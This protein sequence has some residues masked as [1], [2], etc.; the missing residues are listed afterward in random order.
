MPTQGLL[1]GICVGLLE[2]PSIAL[3]PDYFKSR[4]GMA[5]GLAISGA[6]MDGLIYS[7]IF[8]ALLSSTNFGWATRII[9]FIVFLTLGLAILIIRS[10]DASRK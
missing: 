6:P 10:L 9:G 7:V 4:L 8:R 5:L 3:I 2:I 1:P